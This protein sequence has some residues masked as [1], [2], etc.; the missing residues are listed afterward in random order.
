MTRHVAS[1]VAESQRPTPLQPL[2]PDLSV[3]ARPAQA[4]ALAGG[5]GGQNH[6]LSQRQ[7]AVAT[8][9]TTD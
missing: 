2:R 4:P 5:H 3:K 1:H 7:P 9:Q 8:D 6:G